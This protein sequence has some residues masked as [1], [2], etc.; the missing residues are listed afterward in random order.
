MSSWQTSDQTNILRSQL[1]ANRGQHDC[2]VI[3]VYLSSFL[4]F[5][6]W[7]FRWFSI[8]FCCFT[9]HHMYF[10]CFVHSLFSTFVV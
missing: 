10:S 1:E 3:T 2:V 9:S 5:S 8:V 6:L 7:L 4:R